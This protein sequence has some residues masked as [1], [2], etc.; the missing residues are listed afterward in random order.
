MTL[1]EYKYLTSASWN[2]R[3]QPLTNNMTRDKYTGRYRLWLNGLFVP[4]SSP[5]YYF[6]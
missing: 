1:D 4:N 2:E 5:F 3:Y 6:K